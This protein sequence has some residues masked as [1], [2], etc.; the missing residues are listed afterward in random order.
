MF[1]SSHITRMTSARLWAMSFVFLN[2]LDLILTVIILESGGSELNPLIRATLELGVPATAALK[3]GVSSLFAWLLLRLRR[4][5]ALR[6]ATIM[7]SGVCLFNAAGLIIGS[8][9]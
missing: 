2:A 4:E 6:L 5:G 3:I 1:D 8:S 9:L 7:I